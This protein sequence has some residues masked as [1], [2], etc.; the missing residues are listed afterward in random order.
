MNNPISESISENLSGLY[1]TPGHHAQLMRNITGG[2]KVKKKL[3]T[4]LVLA[5]A[6]ILLA[7]TAF[8]AIILT[9]SPQADA[10]A[11]ARAALS[12]KYGLTPDV[13]G[14]FNLFDKQEGDTWT[15]LA[16]SATFHPSLVGEYTVVLDK[17]GAA[18]TW[19]HDNA[20][21]AA[22]EKAGL[23]SPVWGQPQ[24]AEALRNPDAADKINIKLHQE[25]P[26][27]PDPNM[28]GPEVLKGRSEDESYWNG[29]IIKAGQP[30]PDDLTRDKALEI[31]KQAIMEDFGLSQAEVDAG[32]IISERFSLRESGGTL[33]G[34]S[35]YMEKDGVA[36]DCGITM[37]GKTGEVLYTSII[38]GGNG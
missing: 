32:E 18:A 19:S 24:I 3:T 7:I 1:I 27:G 26:V 14:T 2:S 36:W 11:R 29:E 17:D 21:K 33:W 4:S 31:A 8:A 28:P 15:V 10:L 23:E 34:F 22:W 5:M 38:T 35:I 6:L 30:G 37:D 25:S 16:T 13:I 12:E 9:R 20:D